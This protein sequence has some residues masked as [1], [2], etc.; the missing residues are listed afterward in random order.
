LTLRYKRCI[1]V[2]RYLITMDKKIHF[3][4]Y[5]SNRVKEIRM[6]KGVKQDVLALKLGLTRTSLINIEKGRHHV[7][8]YM[9][10]QIAYYLE[11]SIN[12]F[13][14][15][16]KEFVTAYADD[17]NKIPE[18]TV[19]E[20]SSLGLINTNDEIKDTLEQFIKI[21]NKNNETGNI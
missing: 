18:I 2:C 9:L 11:A 16:M 13:L 20:S 1:F 14:P 12:E 5:I 4:Q 8:L 19:N 6:Q 21:L 7:N 3:F 10:F 17:Y 15:N